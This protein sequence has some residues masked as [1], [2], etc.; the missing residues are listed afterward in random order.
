MEVGLRARVV[1]TS[2]EESPKHQMTVK[3]GVEG[4]ADEAS[5]AEYWTS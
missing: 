4:D 3:R 2:H 1:A 5:V